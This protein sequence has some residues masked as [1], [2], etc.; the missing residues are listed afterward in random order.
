M[1]AAALVVVLALAVPAAAWAA[2]PRT[3]LPDVEDEVMCVTCNVP[4]NVADSPQASSQRDEIRRLVDQGLTKDQ[5]KAR[6]VDEYGE[7]VLALPEDDGVA[8]GLYV[9]PIAVLLAM[10]L[11][12]ALV[13]PRWRARG[14]TPAT[15][16]AGPA[17]SAAELERVD[18]DLAKYD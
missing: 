13:L 4:L 18:D 12:A 11:A 6:L 17:V 9:V 10:A 1:R 2:E 3:S 5:I 14:Q 7:N 8:A 15:A 16:P